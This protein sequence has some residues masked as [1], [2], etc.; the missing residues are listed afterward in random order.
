MVKG[1]TALFQVSSDEIAKTEERAVSASVR[2]QDEVIDDCDGAFGVVHEG[3]KAAGLPVIGKTEIGDRSVQRRRSEEFPSS[4]V[5]V[6]C[7][8][9]KYW[10]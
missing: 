2:G 4:F 10:T 3:C 6:R 8:G 5:L 1:N 7:S 9:P